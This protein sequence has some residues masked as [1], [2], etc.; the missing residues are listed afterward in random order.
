MGPPVVA[1]EPGGTFNGPVPV[2]GFAQTLRSK[3]LYGRVDTKAFTVHGLYSL[4]PARPS[5][6]RQPW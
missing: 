3:G 1:M 5:S 6:Q 2:L 4:M